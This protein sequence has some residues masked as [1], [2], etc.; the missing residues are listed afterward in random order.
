MANN[1]TLFSATL[2][3][4][5]KQKAWIEKNLISR[6]DWEELPDE[7]V[8]D[9]KAVKKVTALYEFYGDEGF[10]NFD[11]RFEGE[12]FW[13][14]SEESGSVDDAASVVE[15]LLKATRSNKVFSIEWAETC[16]KP[17]VGEFGGGACVVTR[18]GAKWVNTSDLATAMAKD[19]KTAL[20]GGKRKK[21]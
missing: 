14:Y 10:P 7:V 17:R 5:A 6:E 1:H 9:E 3:I 15:A 13:V 19:A 11:W 2:K 20:R 16:E 4:T 8:E 18:L 21:K 12:G